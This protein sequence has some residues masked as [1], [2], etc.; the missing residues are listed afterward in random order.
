MSMLD[1]ATW[2]AATKRGPLTPRSNQ[3]KAIDDALLVYKG[4]PIPANLTKVKTALDAWIKAKGPNWKASTRNSGGAVEA[5]KAE[6][7]QKA[8]PGNLAKAAMAVRLAP[9]PPVPPYPTMTD[10]QLVTRFTTHVKA[11]FKN[12]WNPHDAVATGTRLLDGIVA[13]H[14]ACGIP[15]IRAEIKSLPPGYN[16]FFD[17]STWS[18]QVSDTKFSQYNMTYV[19]PPANTKPHPYFVNIAE[20]LYHEGR[21]CEQWWHMARYAAHGA[22]PSD[23]SQRLSIPIAVATEAA[24]KPMKHNDPMIKKTEEWFNSVYGDGRRGI[25]LSALALKRAAHPSP[26][27]T[28]SEQGGGEIYD[29]YQGNLAEE[30]D[31]WGIQNLVR[32][33]F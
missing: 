20:T 31:A 22:S 12:H 28:P 30:I 27:I 32:A 26:K 16:G 1:H 24:K 6:I 3:L 19:D 9:P 25:V 2:M 7:D 18:I 15:D 4:A 23:V 21:H 33:K 14:R 5:L 13:V 17:F 10:D 29:Q 11:C 8:A